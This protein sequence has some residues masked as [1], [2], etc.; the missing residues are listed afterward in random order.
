MRRK[1]VIVTLVVFVWMGT[2]AQAEELPP[3]ADAGADMQVDVV[4]SADGGCRL[5]GGRRGFD[6]GDHS[7][8]LRGGWGLNNFSFS[9]LRFRI[10]NELEH[11]FDP[12]PP[13]VTGFRPG[14][15]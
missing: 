14:S 11:F 7:F 6:M 4:N 9:G 3:H 1:I 8:V 12:L 10:W 2:L 5:P 13:V 15:F